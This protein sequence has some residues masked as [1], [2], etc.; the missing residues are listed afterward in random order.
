MTD[1]PTI[2]EP[3]PPDSGTP[4]PE[5]SVNSLTMAYGD[6]VVMR[7]LTFQI[8]DKPLALDV[9]E[10]C[11]IG[12]L[13]FLRPFTSDSRGVTSYCNPLGLSRGKV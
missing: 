10:L 7:D 13:H 12:F 2:S 6:Y 4:E 1:A 9:F 3:T 5:I 11:A 8:H